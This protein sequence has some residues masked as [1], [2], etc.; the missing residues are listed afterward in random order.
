[1][2][3]NE[4]VEA[5]LAFIARDD[6]AGDED[7][8]NQLALE[9]FAYQFECNVPLR[10]FCRQRSR[11]PRTVKR[12]QDIPAVPISAFKDLELSCCASLSWTNSMTVC[13]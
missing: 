4:I 6:A 8:F 9:L 2:T 3:E 1:V 7:A 13:R 10:N 5:I 11:T 12:W